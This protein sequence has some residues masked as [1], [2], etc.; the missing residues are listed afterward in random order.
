MKA[1]AAMLT[2]TY[3]TQIWT[4]MLFTVMLQFILVVL[5]MVVLKNGLKHA[6]VTAAKYTES[7]GCWHQ[8]QV[9][10]NFSKRCITH[11]CS[12]HR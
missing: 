3:E 2:H 10:V 5:K 1:N 9:P 7:R 8:F 11:H 4:W 12:K 6:Q